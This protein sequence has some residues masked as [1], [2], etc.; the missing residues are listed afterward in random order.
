MRSVPPPDFQGEMAQMFAEQEWEGM[1]TA[2]D[3]ELVWELEDLL[4]EDWRR[5]N[6]QT[7]K[8]GIRRAG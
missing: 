6:A 3:D 2:N 7:D 1:Q 5:K 8:V 4:K